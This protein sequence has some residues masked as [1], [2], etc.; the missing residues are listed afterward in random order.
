VRIGT[1]AALVGKVVVTIGMVRAARLTAQGPGESAGPGL[2]VPV[3][4][5][6]GSGRRFDLSGLVVNAAYGD[7]TPAPPSDAAPAKP[8]PTSVGRGGTVTGLYAFR[9]GSG[10]A[11][12]LRVEVS[13]DRAQRVLVFRR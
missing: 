4:V 12:T 5:R 8:L 6:N 1:A 7:G 9:A 11:T 10:A 2:V 13:S 3:T